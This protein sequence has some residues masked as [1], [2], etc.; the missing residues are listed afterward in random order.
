VNPVL[1]W[2]VDY[3]G[4]CDA[5]QATIRAQEEQGRTWKF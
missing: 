1:K 4:I 3:Q 5:R 2:H